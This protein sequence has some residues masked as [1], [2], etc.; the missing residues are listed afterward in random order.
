MNSSSTSLIYSLIIL[1]AQADN[2]I[3][4][5]VVSTQ[6]LHKEHVQFLYCI[7]YNNESRFRLETYMILNSID[8]R[9]EE[10]VKFMQ[11]DIAVVVK[12][13]KCLLDRCSRGNP[14]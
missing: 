7:F 11:R 10:R 8:I 2:A 12:G 9:V 13:R 14:G 3:S 1:C 4:Q 6:K 5:H